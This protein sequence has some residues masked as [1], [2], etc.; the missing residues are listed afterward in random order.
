MIPALI[1][2]G[3]SLI[4]GWLSN[5]SQKQANNTNVGWAREQWADQKAMREQDIAIQREFAKNSAGWQFDDLME[6]ADEAGIHRLAAIGGAS[7]SSYQP[8]S[9]IPTD[10]GQQGEDFGFIGDAASAAMSQ[11]LASQQNTRSQE[12]HEAELRRLEAETQA[13]TTATKSRR[14]A[15]DGGHDITTK[16]QDDGTYPF[17][18]PDPMSHR[19]E[20]ARIH[21]GPYN[22]RYVI[23]SGGK[24]YITTGKNSPQAIMEELTGEIS[25]IQG[26]IEAGHLVRLDRPLPRGT[27][28]IN[29][30]KESGGLSI[31]PSTG[32]G[33]RRNR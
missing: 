31:A 29:V 15:N 17:P 6:A 2:G 21:G 9:T 5:K 32:S 22:N 30:D 24:L 14:A 19:L 25:N 8:G 7:G 11:V 33:A 1:A 13:I 4:G 26:M 23:K 10:A 20:D 18:V 12:R 16:Q 27:K 28:P 3:A